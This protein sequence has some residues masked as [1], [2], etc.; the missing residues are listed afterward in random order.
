LFLLIAAS[1]GL[2]RRLSTAGL[3]RMAATALR[4]DHLPGVVFEK[5]RELLMN[6]QL[7][8]QIVDEGLRIMFVAT[9]HRNPQNVHHGEQVPERAGTPS[10]RMSLIINARVS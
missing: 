3:A 5:E 6:R 2:F 8:L 4:C 10:E 7:T 9:A 1:S